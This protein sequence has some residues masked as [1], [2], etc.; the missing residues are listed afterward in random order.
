MWMPLVLGPSP[1]ADMHILNQN[2][3]T[4]IYHYMDL[5]PVNRV[6][7]VDSAILAR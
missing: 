1:R 3:I 6:Y 2:N 5:G 4:I 7:A